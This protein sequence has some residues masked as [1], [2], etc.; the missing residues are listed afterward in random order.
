[1]SERVTPYLQLVLAPNPGPM[2]LDGTNTWILGDPDQVPPVV[3]DPGPLDDDHLEAIMTACNGRIAE[4][5]LTHR[6]RDHS[7]AAPRLARLADC[8]VRSADPALR[9]GPHGLTDGES[10]TVAGATWTALSTPGHTTDSVSFLLS[11]HDGVVRLIT[12]DTVLGRG[13]SVITHPDGN[14]G[15]YLTSLDVLEETVRTADV[16]EI[17]PGH[18]PR[19]GEPL[20]WVRFYRQHRLERLQQVREAWAAGDRTPPEVVSRVYAEVDRSVWPAAEQSV[21]AQL[22]YLASEPNT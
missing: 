11:G 15:S 8:G 1:M 17:L 16:V 5:V 21:A 22:E 14:L 9:I 2:T 6:H 3:V 13:T 18:G 4:I 19:V 20:A 12:G 7:D 10:S